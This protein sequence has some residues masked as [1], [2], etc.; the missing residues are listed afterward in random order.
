MIIKSVQVRNFRSI[1]DETLDC[2]PLTVLVGA[3]GSGKS[4]FLRALDVFY[5][6]DA[7]Y[8]PQDFYSEDTSDPI[9]IT[10]TF[11]N[12]AEEE[13]KLF[14]K[15]VHADTLRV[16]KELGWGQGSRSQR[17]WGVALQ[18]P[19]FQAVR[20]PDKFAD[21]RTAYRQLVESGK[22]A[23]LPSTVRSIADLEAALDGFEQAHPEQCQLI[24]EPTQ[25]FGYK[26]VGGTRLERFTQ[27]CLVPAVRDASEDATEG[28]GAV[29]SELMELVVRSALAQRQDL[30]ELRE[31]T[32][33]EYGQIVDEAKLGELQ[34]LQSDLSNTLST[35][36]PGT[37][38]DLRWQRGE[39]VQIRMPVADVRL[40]ED[41]YPAA[42]G[43]AGHGL[44]RAFIM[45]LLE[46]LAAAEAPK[47][48]VAE[49]SET[50]PT[51]TKSRAELNLVLAI[52]EPELYQHPNR[53]RHLASV[54]LDLAEGQIKGV[55]AQMQVIYS[56]H[57]PLFVGIERF[58]R[59]R[60]LR[61]VSTS[62]GKPR[63]TKVFRTGLCEVK[64]ALEDAAQGP[65]GTYTEEALVAR[66]RALMTPWVN[67]GFFADVA[68]LVEGEDDRAAVLGAAR[69][70][71][72][73][74]ESL[75]ISVIPCMSKNNLD[76]P[77]AIF[78]GFGMPVFL[79]WDSDYGKK[80]SK[81]EDNHRLLRLCGEPIQEDWP[82]R[83]GQNFACFKV[84]LE[85]TL[86]AELGEEV[87][88]GLLDKCREEF[89]IAKREQALKNPVTIQR[90]IEGASQQG[91]EVRSLNR[92]LDNIVKLRDATQST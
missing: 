5:T 88:N 2:E 91:K 43:S 30:A 40:V 3:N 28:R 90:V 37:S 26:E 68:V 81:P 45:T 14:P 47:I 52:E 79:I 23:G 49:G 62:E 59:I 69:A 86:E 48:E 57:S 50:T 51:T 66:L 35:Y 8:G 29:I 13:R 41:D 1:L 11:G 46:H 44:Q 74:L 71:R 67:E 80:G 65:K 55:A 19:D 22:Y 4:A 60:L 42:V 72:L 36:A 9:T 89:S 39:G 73:N 87:F 92:I 56:T 21:K 31:R 61:K 85:T 82:D 15:Y 75:G 20:T 76:R 12:L 18:L 33:E 70:R 6:P 24:R 7:K 64:K 63:Q 17:Y 25:F 38:V 27:F 10:V 53:Q 84:D 78:M 34:T 58:N 16:E 54:L 77:A 83:V 32:Q